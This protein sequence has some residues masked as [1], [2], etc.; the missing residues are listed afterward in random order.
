MH[1]G[2][3]D[4]QNNMGP[5][6]SWKRMWILNTRGQEIRRLVDSPYEAG[7]HSIRWD[8]KDDRGNAVSSGVYIYQL[9]AGDFLQVKKM[10]LLR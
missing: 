3:V 10:I 4:P 8:S 5:C 9:Q 7:Y 2:L 6:G 1:S